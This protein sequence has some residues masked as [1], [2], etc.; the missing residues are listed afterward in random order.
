MN[1]AKTE[2]RYTCLNRRKLKFAFWTFI[3]QNGFAGNIL[4]LDNQRT[5]LL[6]YRPVP[7]A[8][9]QCMDGKC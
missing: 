7:T 9:D 2:A 4:G 6:P 8:K 5:G 3:W 1:A